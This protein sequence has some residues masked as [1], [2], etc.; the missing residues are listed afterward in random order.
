MRCARECL[1][2]IVSIYQD[3]SQE[4]A[5][6]LLQ[7]VADL[8]FLTLEQQSTAERDSFGDVM[9][10][11]AQ[12]AGARE[13]AQLAERI[14]RTSPIPVELLR[15]LAQDEIFIARPILQYSPCLREGD[16]VAITSEVGQAHL[17]A[18]AHRNDLTIPVTDILIARGEADVHM[19]LAQNVSAD[20]SEESVSRLFRT[21]ESHVALLDILNARRD[22][23]P[24]PI[25]KLR[26]L[27]D[28]E[29]WHRMAET[30]LMSEETVDEKLAPQQ[31]A[32]ESGESGNDAASEPEPAKAPAVDI[33]RQTSASK[34]KALVEA[35]RAGQVIETIEIL[36]SITRLDKAMVEHCMFQ[37]H[38]PA[39]MV[40]CKAHKL[41]ASTFNSLLQ[42]RENHTETPINDTIGLI[43]RYEAMTPDTAQRV[44]RFADK[45][46]TE[47]EKQS[48]T[49]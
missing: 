30:L 1:D 44:I 8:Y 31:P 9:I 18:T 15:H 11:M 26:R 37:A 47:P 7:K 14:A 24:N 49:A 16:L 21:A 41:A 19:A 36:A 23:A 43:R 5:S 42:M 4:N 45:S 35:A 10:R 32:K 17:S 38:L 22:T 34:E 40:L 2:E 29:F 33:F 13:R 25:R 6:Q 3:G 12:S 39:L 27:A 46:R 20:L 28:A 48:A